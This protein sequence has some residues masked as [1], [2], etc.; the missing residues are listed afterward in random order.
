MG[1]DS[2]SFF[3][4]S[5]SGC[6]PTLTIF[7]FIDIC[8]CIMIMYVENSFFLYISFLK[9]CNTVTMSCVCKSVSMKF[10][11]H[12][13]G[14]RVGCNN[15]KLLNNFL[16]PLR[17]SRFGVS[18][19]VTLL[20]HYFYFFVCTI[21]KKKKTFILFFFCFLFVLTVCNELQTKIITSIRRRRYS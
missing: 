8:I 16:S 9:Q 18:L 12:S 6:T 2:V 19:L 1:T 4:M 11:L 7:P 21:Y 17:P 5:H 20:C 13:F 14:S 10:K 15:E 3:Y